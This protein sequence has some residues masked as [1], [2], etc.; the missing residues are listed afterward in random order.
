MRR[1]EDP[2]LDDTLLARALG[3][4]ATQSAPVDD[5]TLAQ[6]LGCG[7]VRDGAARATL[8]RE[9]QIAAGSGR[10]ERRRLFLLLHRAIADGRV[11]HTAA[12]WQL[13]PRA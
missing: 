5:D 2:R 4:L 6:A 1:H 12:G 13:P 3:Y 9:L 11:R 8:P 7:N 10:R